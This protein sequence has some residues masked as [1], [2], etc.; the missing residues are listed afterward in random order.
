MN[1]AANAIVGLIGLAGLVLVA[2]W[3]LSDVIGDYVERR[4]RDNERD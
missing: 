4:L 2:G 1:H 3:W